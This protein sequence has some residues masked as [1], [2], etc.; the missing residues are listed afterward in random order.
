MDKIE[1]DSA[2]YAEPTKPTKKSPDKHVYDTPTTPSKPIGR[3]PQVLEASGFFNP[4]YQT[5]QDLMQYPDISSIFATPSS[6]PDKQLDHEPG[7]S[8]C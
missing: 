2:I 7:E 5:R 3:E 4:L 8:S 6:P 1:A